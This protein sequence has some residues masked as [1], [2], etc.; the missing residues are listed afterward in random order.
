MP[1][2]QK[3]RCIFTYSS[4]EDNPPENLKY[5]VQILDEVSTLIMLRLILEWGLLKLHVFIFPLRKFSYPPHNEF[6]GGILV[7][8]GLSTWRRHQMETFSSVLAIC[9][10]NS[11]ITGEFPTQR[12]VMWSFDVFFDL[13]L[14]ERLGKQSW[15]W[16]FE[17]PLC[18]FWRHSIASVHLSIHP[19]LIPCPLCSAYSSGW[20]HFIFIHLI[21]QLQKVCH[22]YSSFQNLNFRQFFKFIILTLSSLD[23]GSDVND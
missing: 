8:L 3:C 12:P 9:A 15:G 14:N 20:I 11:P 4:A 7:S 19:S 16:W 10:G 2:H 6:V 21:K 17:T 13:C 22:V 18:P 5:H 1:V 23:M